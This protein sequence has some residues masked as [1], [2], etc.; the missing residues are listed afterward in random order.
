MNSRDEE[1]AGEIQKCKIQR[2]TV[3]FGAFLQE[4]RLNNW[5]TLVDGFISWSWNTK[6]RR[7]DEVDTSLRDTH[8]M[9][10]WGTSGQ[11][12]CTSP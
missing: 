3:S 4:P 9:T 10:V 2:D 8:R 11:S 5:E 6:C 7:C 1:S 12:E